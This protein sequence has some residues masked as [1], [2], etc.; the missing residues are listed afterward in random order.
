MKGNKMFKQFLFAVVSVFV[1]STAVFSNTWTDTLTGSI[2]GNV[3]L[4]NTK[5]YLD[6]RSSWN[7]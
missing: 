4:Q 2:T 5:R 1:L 7:R 6:G 3:T